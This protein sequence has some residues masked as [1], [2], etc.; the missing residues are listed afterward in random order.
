MKP[1]HFVSLLL[2]ILLLAGCAREESGTIQSQL[3]QAKP[4]HRGK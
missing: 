1:R 2:L 3:Q 4:G